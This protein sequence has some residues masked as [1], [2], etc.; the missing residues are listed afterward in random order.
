M[1]K[2]VKM[3]ATGPNRTKLRG[4]GDVVHL[5]AQPIARAIDHVAGTHLQDCVGC[6]KRREKLNKAIPFGN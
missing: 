5:V 1:I 4:L 2:V 6:E 3:G